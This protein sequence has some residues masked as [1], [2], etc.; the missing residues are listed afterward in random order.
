MILVGQVS[1]LSSLS[2]TGKWG[3]QPVINGRGKTWEVFPDSRDP[4]TLEPLVIRHYGMAPAVSFNTSASTNINEG[5]HA[6]SVAPELWVHTV[7]DGKDRYVRA[8]DLQDGMVIVTGRMCGRITSISRAPRMMYETNARIVC[9]VLVSE[10]PGPVELP[11]GLQ[12][13]ELF[14]YCWLNLPRKENEHVEAIP[15]AWPTRVH[16]GTR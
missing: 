14:G 15:V 2:K 4:I 11:A 12:I 6:M 7:R 3:S 8:D 10:Q 1:I 9:D 5:Q 16:A 13:S